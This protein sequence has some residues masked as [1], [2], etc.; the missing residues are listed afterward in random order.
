MAWAGAVAAPA[1]DA[2]DLGFDWADQAAEQYHAPKA[3]RAS[4]TGLHV[5]ER[6]RHHVDEK[7][8]RMVTHHVFKHIDKDGSG[9]LDKRELKV[10]I[11]KGEKL[12]KFKAPPFTVQAIIKSCDADKSGDLDE[13]ELVEIVMK[14]FELAKS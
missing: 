1:H 13:E 8:V 5:R 6:L 7:K 10:F 3:G 12:L 9:R 11:Q 4:I 14:L 2:L